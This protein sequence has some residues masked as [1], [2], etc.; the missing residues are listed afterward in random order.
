MK[1]REDDTLFITELM[2]ALSDVHKCFGTDY[3]PVVLA[4]ETGRIHHIIEMKTYTHPTQ[5]D[6]KFACIEF[7]QSRD[8]DAPVVMPEPEQAQAEQPQSVT[9]DQFE[10]AIKTATGLTDF[11]AKEVLVRLESMNYF[12]VGQADLRSVTE[13][14]REVNVLRAKVSELQEELYARDHTGD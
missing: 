12:L 9:L 5:D 7:K 11:D 8:P 10:L 4:D 13:A 2:Q 6:L 1:R 14:R 3:M